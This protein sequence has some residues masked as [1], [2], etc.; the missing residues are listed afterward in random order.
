MIGDGRGILNLTVFTM[1]VLFL[2][3][4]ISMQLF[5]GDFGFQGPA[6]HEDPAMRFDSFYQA[7][8]SLYQVRLKAK[9]GYHTPWQRVLMAIISFFTF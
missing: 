7:F 8:L 4:P 6:G 9:K 5:G 3:T 2:L 1:V